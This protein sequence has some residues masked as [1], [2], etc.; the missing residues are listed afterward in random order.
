MKATEHGNSDLPA[1]SRVFWA[2]H[3]QLAIARAMVRT[4]QFGPQLDELFAQLWRLQARLES[5]ESIAPRTSGLAVSDLCQ[6]TR[7]N[8]LRVERSLP[9]FA[10]LH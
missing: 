6:F 5:F 8:L 10:T 4:R 2:L 9:E 3:R 1:I 7:E